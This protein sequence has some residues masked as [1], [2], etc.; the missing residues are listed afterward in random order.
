MFRKDY[1]HLDKVNKTILAS[2]LEITRIFKS[3][4][5]YYSPKTCPY[6]TTDP[7]P[8]REST[9]IV[10]VVMIWVAALDVYYGL[11]VLFGVG[12]FVGFLSFCVEWRRHFILRQELT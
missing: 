1:L 11:V 6:E 5:N 2:Q 3:Y 10:D 4:N 9:V 12:V 7:K 8:L